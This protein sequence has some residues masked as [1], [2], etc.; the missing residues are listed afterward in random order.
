MN[1]HVL[2]QQRPPLSN[3]RGRSNV[4]AMSGA[5]ALAGGFFIV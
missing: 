1:L 2:T 4:P 3:G 5:P